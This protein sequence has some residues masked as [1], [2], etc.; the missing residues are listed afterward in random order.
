MCLAGSA[1]AQIVPLSYWNLDETRGIVAHDMISGNRGIHY[2]GV[3]VGE[4]G[5]LPGADHSVGYY[6]DGRPG[7][8]VVQPSDSFL[9]SEG[10]LTFSMFNT[11][12]IGQEGLISKDARGYG[13]GGHFSAW[14]SANTQGIHLGLADESRYHV[15]HTDAIQSDR[16][17]NIIFS[18]GSSGMKLYLDG[19]LVDEDTYT[20]GMEN[21]YEP[22]VFGASERW[23]RSGWPYPLTDLFS[24]KLDEI[25]IF[26]TAL[27]P[28]EVNGSLAALRGVPLPGTTGLAM[29]GLG[30]FSIRSRRRRI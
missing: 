9:L 27:T 25:A 26:D 18:W 17:Y 21:N 7:F 28:Q 4:T 14:T 16:W 29:L 15:V 2:R 3:N 10:T 1:G 24:G 20:G 8:T 22:L 6:Q 30:T 23:S 13:N 19:D 11:G 5:S 12:T